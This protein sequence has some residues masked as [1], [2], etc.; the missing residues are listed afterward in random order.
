MLQPKT[1]CSSRSIVAPHGRPHPDLLGLDVKALAEDPQD[2]TILY[3]AADGVGIYRSEDAGLTWLTISNGL[4]S[5]S[6]K[7]INSIAVTADSQVFIGTD[8]GMFEYSVDSGGALIDVIEF[9]HEGLDH[10]V[11]S[12]N[13]QEIADLDAGVHPGWRRTGQSFTAYNT[14][15]GNASLVCRFY[16]PP[17]Y[18]DSHF[19]AASA[20][21]C[22]EVQAKYPFFV[23]EPENGFYIELP[24]P[25]TGAC[26]AGSSPV[27]RVWNGLANANHRYLTDASTRDLMVALGGVAEGYGTDSVIM[28]SAR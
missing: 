5:L 14:K 10:Y 20:E 8:A 28:C 24:D 22:A 17:E 3:A 26:T 18:G 25:A 9:Y 7:H 2:P 13:A 23:Y 19:Y 15:V 12:A 4:D 16:L 6:S 27:Y 1:A 21:E 11:I